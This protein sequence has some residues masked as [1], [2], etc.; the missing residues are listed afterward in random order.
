MYQTRGLGALSLAGGLT[1]A[2]LFLGACQPV[3][4]PLPEASQSQAESTPAMEEPA[5]AEAAGPG[6]IAPEGETRTLEGMIWQVAK[7]LDAD[8]ALRKPVA[9]ATMTFQEGHVGGSAGCNNFS[10]PYT[11]AGQQ[12]TIAQIGTTMMFCEEAIMAQE[13]AILTALGKA[14]AYASADDGIALL[15]ATG[16]VVLTLVPHIPQPQASLTGVVWLATTINN[17]QQAVVSLLEGTRITAIFD[18]KGTLSGSAG[19]NNYRASYTLDG[20]TIAL[21]PLVSTRKFCSEPEG[22]MEQEANYLQALETVATWSIRGNVLELRD[23]SGALAV[24]FEAASHS[25]AP[26]GVVTQGS[27]LWIHRAMCTL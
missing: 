2:A 16:R 23:A 17:G 6:Q 14:A 7:Y 10:A 26:A 5:E 11:L 12:L 21:T 20:D 24:S 1:I 8:N 25:R 19:C 27:A 4:S 13:Q 9:E 15:D 18:E 3:T 22:V